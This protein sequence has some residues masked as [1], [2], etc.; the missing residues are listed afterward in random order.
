M[1]FQVA[2]LYGANMPVLRAGQGVG[3]A[4]VDDVGAELWPLVDFS[5]LISSPLEPSGF[6]LLIV[7]PYCC[8]KLAMMA[9]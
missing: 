1:S 3:V 2:T 4:D 6:S 9:A 8:L 5:A 7:M